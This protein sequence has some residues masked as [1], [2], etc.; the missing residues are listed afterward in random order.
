MLTT[1]PLMTG[2]PVLPSDGGKP[3]GLSRAGAGSAREALRVR[4]MGQ[5]RT[6]HCGRK[7][8][9]TRGKVHEKVLAG[10]QEK[11]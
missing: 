2:S 1:S 7:L 6:P 8:G 4:A 9:L 10:H 3:Q 11:S 5:R